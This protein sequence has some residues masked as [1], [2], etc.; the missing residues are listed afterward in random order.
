MP[1][2]SDEQIPEEVYEHVLDYR[3]WHGYTERERLLVEFCERYMS[4]YQQ[5]CFDDDF[6]GRLKA[7]LTD[8]ELG[9]L[10]LLAG[11]W[12]LQRRMLHLLLGIEAACELPGRAGYTLLSDSK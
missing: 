7:C 6:W 10:C 9:D 12:E 11:H 3:T 4:D 1:G 2:Y 8:V 5:L